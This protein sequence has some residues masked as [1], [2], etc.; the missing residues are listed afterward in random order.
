MSLLIREL[1]TPFGTFSIAVDASG[2]VVR[3]GFVAADELRGDATAEIVGAGNAT[4]AV[5]DAVARYCA[6]D[7]DAL[8]QIPVAQPGGPFMQR[9]WEQ[10]R[11]VAPGET[12]TYTELAARAGSP[13]AVRAAGSACAR[14]AVALIVPCHRIVRSDGTFGGYQF[15]P[16]TKRALLD[17]ERSAHG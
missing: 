16:A 11:A 3:S 1:A 8:A 15:G 12:I 4:D 6:G 14:N 2:A 13:G 9:A 7:V 10:M 17:F 5:A